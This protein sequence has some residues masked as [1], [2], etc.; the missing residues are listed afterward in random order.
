MF[1]PPDL[2]EKNAKT[3]GKSKSPLERAISFDWRAKL[4][5]SRCFGGA[6]VSLEKSRGFSNHATNSE[7]SGL[8]RSLALL[9][10]TRDDTGF[11]FVF[12]P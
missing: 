12:A 2:C 6:D 3:R 4:R 10:E 11:G 5:L 7:K 8:G 1:R 9:P